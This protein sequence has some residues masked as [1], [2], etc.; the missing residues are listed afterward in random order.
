V[1]G[2][3]TPPDAVLVRSA[4]STGASK[5]FIFLKIIFPAAP[6]EIFTRIRPGGRHG[7]ACR[8]ND[9][10]YFRFGISGAILD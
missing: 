2:I 1:S 3:K 5:P 8:G 10:R 9:R 7:G 6:P 4:K